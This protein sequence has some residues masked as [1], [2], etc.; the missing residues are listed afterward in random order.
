[1]DK[2]NSVLSELLNKHAPLKSINI[3]VRPDAPW[4][5]GEIKAA[6]RECRRAERKMR[7]SGLQVHKDIYI[8]ASND[9]AF[10]ID[11]AK[12]IYYTSKVNTKDQRKVFNVANELLNKSKNVL[13]PMFDSA[14]DLATRFNDFFITKIADIRRDLVKIQNNEGLN[15]NIFV[16]SI[17]KPAPLLTNFEKATENEIKKII[18]PTKP[19]TCALDPISSKLIKECIDSLLPVITHI[20]N[21][22]L[23]Q[24]IMP[25][26]LKKAVVKPLL[27]KINLILEI[28]KNYRPVSNLMYLSKIIERVVAKRT[29]HHMDIND[30][31]ELYQSSYK[32]YHS[33]ETAVLKVKD[34][35]VTAVDSGK[36]VLLVLLDLSAAFDTV[37][38]E[39]LL[40]VLHERL[41]ISGLALEW[42]RSYLNDRV[43]S[44]LIN[45]SESDIYQLLFGVP[46]GSVLG[47]ILFIIYTSPLGDIMRHYGVMFHLYADDTQLYVSFD[48]EDIAKAFQKMEECIRAI[49][50]WMANSFLKLNDSKT[51]VLLIGSPSKLKSLPNSQLRIGDDYISPTKAVRNIGAMFDSTMSMKY[52]VAAICKG[53]WHHLRMIS[54]IKPYLDSDTAKILMHS[55]VGSR[56][57]N[58]NSLLYGLPKKDLYKLQR[59]QNAAAR[60]VSG[61]KSYDHITPILKNLHWLPIAQRINYKIALLTFKALHGMAPSY[62][63]SL[64]VIKNKCKNLRS[65]SNG[66][67][68]A[69]PITKLVSYGDRSFS[70]AAPKIWNNLPVHCRNARTLDGFKSHLKTYLFKQAFH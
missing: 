39:C 18:L 63:K 66:I 65:N 30:L 11:Q 41:G 13:L 42:F 33:C 45:D 54:Q 20:V 29:L 10:K 68:L 34:D 57:D 23:S 9:V 67:L 53:A 46:Q 22:S 69:K 40:K 19:T 25:V 35:I 49:R 59:V 64:L 24:G 3:K 48:T 4:Y 37:D 28:L 44:V 21:L 6:K 36:C 70:A 62:I 51:E 50:I 15:S 26:S 58:F 2:Y 16:P 38:H 60:I 61:S 52:H 32:K 14:K 1:M 27:K 7:N 55:F 31:H 12:K 17:S 5:T 43:Q 8:A 47:P 56:L